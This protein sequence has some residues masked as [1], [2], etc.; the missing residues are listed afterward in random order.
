MVIASL[1]LSAFTI[2]PSII[3]LSWGFSRHTLRVESAEYVGFFMFCY[4]IFFI[5][6]WLLLTVNVRRLTAHA[7]LRRFW[8]PVAVTTGAYGTYPATS[9][10]A[11]KRNDCFSVALRFQLPVACI[12]CSLM[13]Y[14]TP[15]I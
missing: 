9:P 3:N 2:Y 7:F 11:G 10:A 15:P 1:A 4:A 14:R 13:K 8:K 12:I 5:P 6:L